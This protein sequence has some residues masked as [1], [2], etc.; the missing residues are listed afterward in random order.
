[1]A[2]NVS[3]VDPHDLVRDGRWQGFVVVDARDMKQHIGYTAMAFD[4][5]GFGLSL[6]TGISPF[7]IDRLILV[8]VLSWL[9]RRMDEHRSGVDELLD[10]EA[11]KPVEE[12]P[13]SID[14][15]SVVERIL[16]AGEI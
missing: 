11:L 4:D 9:H 14:V 3:L 13:R 6:G 2:L 15:Q 7:R 12:A 8:E 1:M 10:P 5:H 16:L